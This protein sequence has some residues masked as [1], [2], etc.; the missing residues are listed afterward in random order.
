MDE[1]PEHCLRSY[2]EWSPIREIIVGRADGYLEHFLDASFRLFF[3]DHLEDDVLEGH[4]APGARSI[5][6]PTQVCEELQEDLEGLVDALVAYGAHVLRPQPLSSG[7]RDHIVSPYWTTSITPALNVRDQTIVLGDTLVETAPHVRGR[8]YEN[9]L[10]KPIF[11]HYLT[12]QAKWLSMPRPTLAR[13]TLDP[14]YFSEA[15]RQIDWVLLQDESEALPGLGYEIVF[16]GAQCIR[17][18][19]DVIVNVANR[20][21]ELGY[22]WLQSTLGSE[23]RFHRIY[24]MAD[25]HIDSIVMPLRPGT[26][27]LRAPRYLDYLP[28]ALRS[29][30]II[31]PPEI[32]EHRFPDYSTYGFN[33]ASRFID[34][35]VLSLDDTT[36]VVN[37]LYPELISS[38]EAK[39][40][41]AIPVRH[42]HRRL[43][44]GGFHC[45][46]LDCAR[47]GGPEE[48]LGV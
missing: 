37:S 6:I 5:Q 30:D 31:Y 26:L 38:L 23:F 8:L 43:F 32:S 18:G 10:L 17:F 44:G 27:L 14:S 20:N 9:D 4:P 2:D 3:L 22:Q 39:G 40:F 48:Y 24:R 42:R 15:G 1:R 34:M 33:I 29:W 21:H 36:V 45:F 16:D 46:T 11:Y 12:L 35:N 25:S 47:A 19:K 7:N 13:G 28:A 41:N